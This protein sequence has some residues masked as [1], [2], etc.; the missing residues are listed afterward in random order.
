MEDVLP[1]TSYW[2]T[3]E[4]HIDCVLHD[5]ALRQEFQGHPKQISVAW[6]PGNY[7]GKEVMV[8][9]AYSTHLGKACYLHN[10][11]MAKLAWADVDDS[12]IQQT[13]KG[14]KLTR[15][16]GYNELR[17]LCSALES[18]G[19]CLDDFLPPPRL[20][21]RPLTAD[22]VRV[23]GQ[24]GC[25][26]IVNS[27]AK[28]VV[29]QTPPDLDLGAIP[30]LLSISDQGP[31]NVSALNFLMFSDAAHM[32]VCKPNYLG[33]CDCTNRLRHRIPRQPELAAGVAAP[34]AEQ[35]SAESTTPAK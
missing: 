4:A 23:P 15:V 28:T 7:G 14:K 22:E 13:K 6:D 2:V 32:L 21:L 25:M 12:L 11:H 34:R 8:T 35:A 17:A 16:E 3:Q 27:V 19:M 29:A 9:I 30:C 26:C 10:Q 20:I 31:L 18:I 24:D 1:L 33:G 5:Y